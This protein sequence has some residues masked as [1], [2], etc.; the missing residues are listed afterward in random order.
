MCEIIMLGRTLVDGTG[1]VSLRNGELIGDRAS[2]MVLT[3]GARAYPL[4]A[5]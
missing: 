5:D 4:S 1:A 2:E 3:G